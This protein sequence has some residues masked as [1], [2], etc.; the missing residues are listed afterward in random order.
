VSQDN[1][2]LG[3][4]KTGKTTPISLTKPITFV[5]AKENAVPKIPEADA[6][7]RQASEENWIF[8]K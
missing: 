2:G 5:K 6:S 4:S 1:G 3:F 7:T 8:I